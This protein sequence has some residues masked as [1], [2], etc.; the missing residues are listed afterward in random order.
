ML[1]SLEYFHLFWKKRADNLEGGMCVH[2]ESFA[3][4]KDPPLQK[5]NV[6]KLLT[7]IS[8]IMH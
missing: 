5:M 2:T 4:M 3:H 6:Q 8:L 1:N 7:A